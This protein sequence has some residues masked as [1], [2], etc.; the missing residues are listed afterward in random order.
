[1]STE[2][3]ILKAGARVDAKPPAIR[4]DPTKDPATEDNRIARE[5]MHKTI[6]IG[7]D[8]LEN[9]ALVA[10]DSD[11]P[12]AYGAATRVMDSLARAAASLAALNETEVG[13]RASSEAKKNM[14]L[15]APSVIGEKTTFLGSPADLLKMLDKDKGLIEP[16]E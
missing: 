13:K 4:V 14:S 8:L 11:D 15:E 2:I 12:K 7:I 10:K 16:E 6:V 9:A 3:E 1:M 5:T